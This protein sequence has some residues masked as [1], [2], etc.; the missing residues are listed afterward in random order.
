[1]AE[2]GA[3]QNPVI[4]A[5]DIFGTVAVVN[6]EIGNGNT[7][8]TVF[9]HSMRYPYC[10]IVKD[11]KPHGTLALGMVPGWAD[12]TKNLS[13]R[14][15]AVQ[16]QFRPEYR[17]PGGTQ[18]CIESLRHHAGIRVKPDDPLFRRAGKD[19]IDI[20]LIMNPEQLLSIGLGCVIVANDK[21]EAGGDKV[22][23]YGS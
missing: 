8:K 22:I 14:V 5:K 4:I 18:C 13:V 20:R 16:R 15:S 21:I 7:L 17:R 19:L 11:A 12:S 3:E 6:I 1:V 23:L 2:G 9:L 10:D